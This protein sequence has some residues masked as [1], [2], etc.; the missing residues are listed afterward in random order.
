VNYIFSTESSSVKAEWLTALNTAVLR[1]GR[2]IIILM[3]PIRTRTLIKNFKIKYLGFLVFFL[4]QES[5]CWDCLLSQF[6]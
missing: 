1:L 2:S 4:P 5:R 6:N 3:A